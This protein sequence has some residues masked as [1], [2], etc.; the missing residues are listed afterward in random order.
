MVVILAAACLLLSSGLPLP[1]SA[2]GKNWA[3]V[4]APGSKLQDVSAAELGKLYKGTQKSWPDGK[5]FVV[6]V[7]DPDSAE[8]KSAFEKLFG[9]PGADVKA[10]S[11]VAKANEGKP[12]VKRVGNDEDILRTV[13][14]TPGAIGLV[15]VYSI[16]SSVKVL[17]VDGKLPFDAG[18]VLKGN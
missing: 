5:N 15:D 17:R 1:L 4:V 18:Y 6:V 2:A 13:A 11:A 7:H 8:M 9:A 12:V 3:V 10:A 14:A 16:N